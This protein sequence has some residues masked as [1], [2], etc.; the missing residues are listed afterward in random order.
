[1]YNIHYTYINSTVHIHIHLSCL[2]LEPATPENTYTYVQYTVQ[3]TYIHHRIQKLKRESIFAYGLDFTEILAGA[4]S[5]AVLLTPRSPPL[6]CYWHQRVQLSG[7]IDTTESNSVVLL[8]PRSPT[9]LCYWHQGVQLS[10]VI[11][12]TE[13]NSAVSWHRMES[14]VIFLS[15]FP[16]F[17]ETVS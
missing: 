10:G 11:D 15:F 12:T 13:S 17:K 3:Y 14:N 4:K 7:V 16:Q 2:I 9:Q 8:T 5:F 1:M 6:W